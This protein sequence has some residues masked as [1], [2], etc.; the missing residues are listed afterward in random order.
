MATL[1]TR[2]LSGSKERKLP[3]FTATCVTSSST[4]L[5]EVRLTAANK[6]QLLG[7]ARE[8]CYKKYGGDYSVTHLF[9]ASTG[10]LIWKRDKG[11]YNSVCKAVFE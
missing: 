8:A 9:V 11:W 2:I 1:L 7:R 4:S 6:K 3:E 5:F 10:A